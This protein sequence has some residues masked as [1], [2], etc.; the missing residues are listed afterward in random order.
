[1]TPTTTLNRCY[2]RLKEAYRI[3]V[4]PEVF[5]KRG[6]YESV[7]GK[8]YD[9]CNILHFLE[10]GG[11]DDDQISLPSIADLV[12]NG[13]P[14]RSALSLT[15]SLHDEFKP[16]AI[17]LA[18]S[19]LREAKKA[20]KG[21]GGRENNRET[22][23]Y[24]ECAERHLH[25]GGIANVASYCRASVHTSECPM[26]GDQMHEWQIQTF[27]NWCDNV[28]LGREGDSMKTNT[29]RGKRTEEDYY[30]VRAFWE[31]RKKVLALAADHQTNRPEPQPQAR[32]SRLER[33]NQGSADIKLCANCVHYKNFL[34]DKSLSQCGR[35]RSPIAGEVK[36]WCSQERQYSNRCGP[37]G[38]YWERGEMGFPYVALTLLAVILFLL[39]R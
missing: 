21:F 10:K 25:W 22:Q 37:D 17:S 13:M 39:F 11:P 12:W 8:N 28:G 15:S 36:D 7:I 29:N 19:F 2:D 33:P 26:T 32:C 30:A 34:F 20:T 5:E 23:D 18:D 31:R 4:K 1:M 27:V 38:K 14:L 24:I 6:Y 35:D 3:N 16:G 9:W